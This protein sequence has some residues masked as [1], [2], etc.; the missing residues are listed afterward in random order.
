MDRQQRDKEEKANI[1]KMIRDLKEKGLHRSAYRIW[2][3]HKE[4]I[5][6]AK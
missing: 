5:T 2:E 6:L 1:I 4:F 3:M